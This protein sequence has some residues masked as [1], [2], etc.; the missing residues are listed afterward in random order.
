M[1]SNNTGVVLMDKNGTPF[2]STGRAEHRNLVGLDQISDVTEKALLAS[3]DKDFYHHSGFSFFS[4]VKA[5]YE[6]IA[7]GDATAYGGSTLT[8]QLAKNTLLSNNQTIL[9]K[10][11]ELTVSMAIEQR[12]SK[13]EIL[14]MYLNS[15]YFGDNSFGI[16]AAAENY[17]NKKASDLT[18]AE[19]SMLIGVLPAPSAYS[20]VDGSEKLA[21]ERQNTVLSRMLKNGVITQTQKE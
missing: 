17:F 14:G 3:E 20:P 16:E 2:Y 5:M 15:V 6:N 21:K 11:Q 13:D 7:A 12:Y 9:R 1:N 19:A 10:Y 18:L 8:Q 4:I